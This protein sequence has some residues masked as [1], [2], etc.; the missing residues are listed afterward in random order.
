MKKSRLLPTITA[1]LLV[2]VILFAVSCKEETPVV[3]EVDGITLSPTSISLVEGE[4]GA[5]R[6][7]LSP[8]DATD[9]T[10]TWTSDDSTVAEV[11][12]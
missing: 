9:K 7:T 1:S 11:A 6:A 8:G 5:I 4:V 3:V 2:L 10:V 12:S